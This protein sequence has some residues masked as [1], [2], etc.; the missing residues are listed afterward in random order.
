LIL[1][2]EL[3]KVV[4]KKLKTKAIDIG[5]SIEI[6]STETT[7]G[8]QFKKLSGMGALLRYKI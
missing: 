3:D 8:E 2:K 6:V 1:S 5:A 4:A 7:E